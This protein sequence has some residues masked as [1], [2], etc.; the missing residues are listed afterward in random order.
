M[1]SPLS[2]SSP[3]LGLGE[4]EDMEV[5]KFAKVRSRACISA[6]PRAQGAWFHHREHPLCRH[7]Q[8]PVALGGIEGIPG[9]RGESTLWN[10][11]CVCVGF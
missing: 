4:S 3:P 11:G 5:T 2:V 1:G 7:R 10:P 9:P 6:A 8:K